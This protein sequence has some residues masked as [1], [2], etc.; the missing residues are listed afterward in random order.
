MPVF[1][2]DCA[3]G[4]WGSSQYTTETLIMPDGCKLFLRGWKTGGRDV[5]LLMH[6]LGAHSGW[7]IDMGGSL[8]EHGLTVYAIDHRGFGRT[9][10]MP[11]HVER[12]DNYV[13]DLAV[14]I[15][16]LRQRHKTESE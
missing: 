5:L 13:A 12:F 16:E 3:P 2:D 15:E 4:D 9:E 14:V 1:Y 11:G 6:G 10:G 8:A 7:F